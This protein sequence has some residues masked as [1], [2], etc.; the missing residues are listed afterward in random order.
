MKTNLSFTFEIVFEKNKE[1][2]FFILKKKLIFI[3]KLLIFTKFL[4]PNSIM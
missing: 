1:N 2:I 3:F 4:I